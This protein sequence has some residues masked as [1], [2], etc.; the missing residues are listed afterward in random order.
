MA[1]LWMSTLPA[2]NT[3]NN[4][5]ERPCEYSLDPISG[6]L[7]IRIAE[8]PPE[9]EGTTKPGADLD[10]RPGFHQTN[11]TD[12]IIVLVGEIYSMMETATYLSLVRAKYY[13][14]NL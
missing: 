5:S 8:P 9:H 2:C 14:A 13:N 10:S 6:T 1:D 12:I 4:F 3:A 11:T 7:M